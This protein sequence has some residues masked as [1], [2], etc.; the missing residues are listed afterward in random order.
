MAAEM[1]PA[2][3]RQLNEAFST[4]VETREGVT[5]VAEYTGNMIRDRLREEAFCHKILTPRQVQKSELRPSTR[6]DTVFKLLELEPQ[7]RAMVMSFRG[8][9]TGRVIR[10]PR[11][12]VSFFTVSSE[13]MQKT[14]QELLAYEMPITKIVEDNIAKDMEEIMDREFLRHGEAC[15][16]AMQEEKNGS[17]VSLTSATA[18]DGTCVEYSVRKGE[19]ARQDTVNLDANVR[20]L[21]KRD[22]IAGRQ[23]LNS[24]RLRPQTVL[25]TETD[26]DDAIGWIAQDI[27]YD[28]ASNGT[29]KG[30]VWNE[31]AGL[32]IV[33]TIKNDI[34]RRGNVYFF[35]D[36]N[37]LGRFFFLNAPKFYVDKIANT[38]FFQSWQD[39]GMAFANVQAMVKV[40]LYTGD[41][42]ANDANG[43]LADVTPYPEDQLGW[44]NNRVD[45]GVNFPYIETYLPVGLLV[46]EEGDSEGCRPSSFSSR[47]L[48]LQLRHGQRDP[49]CSSQHHARAAQPSAHDLSRRASPEPCVPLQ[50]GQDTPARS[51]LPAARG[52]PSGTS[53]HL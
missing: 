36:E 39:I 40:E 11:V 18:A 48:T 13:L 24:R 21:D 10:A 28:K 1:N 32:R 20:G 14:E 5:K 38:I 30:F 17:V 43:I 19:L 42:T 6:T 50:Q 12:E 46:D 7:S 25:L 47:V 45:S 44:L 35:A 22:L 26:S 37:F 16:Q 31:L 3:A 8:Q 41:A 53:V 2:L 29:E 9:P 34:L 4:E 51:E 23:M 49:V 15:V 27:G 33:R 52:A